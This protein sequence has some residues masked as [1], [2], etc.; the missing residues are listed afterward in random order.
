MTAILNRRAFLTQCGAA[1]VTAPLILPSRAR[2]ASPSASRGTPA[3]AQRIPAA[4]LRK[5]RALT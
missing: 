5:V 1:T 4:P 2:A 3:A